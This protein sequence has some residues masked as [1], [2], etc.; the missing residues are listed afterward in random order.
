MLLITRCWRQGHWAEAIDLIN[1]IRGSVGEDPF[2][3]GKLAELYLNTNQKSLA[4]RHA[5]RAVADEPTL[6]APLRVLMSLA[7]ENNDQKEI[8]RLQAV[9]RTLGERIPDPGIALSV[10]L[11][12]TSS[13][14]PTLDPDHWNDVLRKRRDEQLA[15]YVSGAQKIEA[16]LRGLAKGPSATGTTPGATAQRRKELAQKLAYAKRVAKAFEQLGPR[17]VGDLFV[18]LD[19]S[20]AK[21][22]RA[23]ALA[24]GE[25]K[26]V[27]EAVIRQQQDVIE[28]TYRGSSESHVAMLRGSS[29][30]SEIRTTYTVQYR[31]QSG[32]VFAGQAEVELYKVDEG[33][34]VPRMLMM[35][36]QPRSFAL[37]PNTVPYVVGYDGTRF[38]PAQEK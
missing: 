19:S 34:W 22:M 10:L 36:G 27:G 18:Q 5:Q 21:R 38:V 9:L 33:C 2:L 13:T 37:D 12:A 11:P 32:V 23:L 6:V 26:G 20:N 31:A 24:Y 1:S 4:L 35:E 3:V 28:C 15:S 30:D 25:A 29:S 17:E 7:I 8:T 16:E 14:Q